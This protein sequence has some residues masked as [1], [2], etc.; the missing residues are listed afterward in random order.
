M[1]APPSTRPPARP[2]P[3]SA[4][5]AL[6]PARPP[7]LSSYYP[8]LRQEGSGG[9]GAI[10]SLAGNHSEADLISPTRTVGN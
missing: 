5:P 1:A 2:R 10:Q 3:A 9:G 6:R 4:T 8:E 7:R